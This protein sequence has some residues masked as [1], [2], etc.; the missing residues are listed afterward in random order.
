M[1]Q[2]YTWEYQSL[3]YTIWE[4]SI[5]NNQITNAVALENLICIGYIQY[6]HIIYKQKTIRITYIGIFRLWYSDFTIDSHW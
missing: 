4:T 3:A 5:N 1:S 6:N 2:I